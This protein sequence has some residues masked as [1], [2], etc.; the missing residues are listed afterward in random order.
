GRVL[1][2]VADEAVDPSFGTGAVKVTPAHDPTDFEIGQRHG[3]PSLNV[4]TAEA[5]ISDAAPEEFRGLGR[6]PARV[7]VL[8]RLTELGR[9]VEVERP[10]VHSVAHCYRCGSEV[11]P[12]IAGLQ[13]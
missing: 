8:E 1:P 7:K 13:W 12:W 4:L 9:V 6:Y 5:H 11:E 10:Y 3:L 2:I